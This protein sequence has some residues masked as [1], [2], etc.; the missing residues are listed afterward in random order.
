MTWTLLLFLGLI[1]GYLMGSL[2]SAIIVSKLFDLPDPLKKGSKN[3]GATNILR[4]AGKKYALIV[5]LVDLLKG[6]VPVLIVKIFTE[7]PIIL[8][9]TCLS[10][11]LGH[12]YPIFFHFKGG[13]GVATALGAFFGFHFM[14]GVVVVVTWLL[15]ANLFLYSSLASL[16]AVL[17]APFYS[18]YFLKNLNAFLPFSIITLIIFYKHRANITRLFDGTESK[19]SFQ[20]TKIRPEPNDKNEKVKTKKKSLR[21]RIAKKTINRKGSRAKKKS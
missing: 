13:K 20:T 5:L 9:F 10:A 16:I 7:E 14:L 3:P 17:L 2:N 6:L 4:L 15:I 18:I 19:I 8:S 12:I 11:V 1:L 21:S